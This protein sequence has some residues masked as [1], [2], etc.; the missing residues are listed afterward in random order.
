[1]IENL[2]SLFSAPVEEDP[3]ELES[4]LQLAA[5]ALLIEITRADHSVATEEQQALKEL[6]HTA[7]EIPPGQVDELLDLAGGAADRATSLYEFTRLINSHYGRRQKLTLIHSM[8]RVAYVDGDL[9]KYE[10][11]LIRQ[12]AELIHVPHKEFIRMKLKAA[13][14]A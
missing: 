12:V 14:S 9:D 10:E 2:K 3:A 5:A 1:M 11:G 13:D 8:W 4:H 6:L 7:L